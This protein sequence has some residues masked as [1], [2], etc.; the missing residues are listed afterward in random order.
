MSHR[1]KKRLEES[2][3]RLCAVSLTNLPAKKG[4]KLSGNKA[5]LIECHVQS[6]EAGV[7]GLGLSDRTATRVL[8]KWILQHNGAAARKA[9]EICQANKPVMLAQYTSFMTDIASADVTISAL[10]K[11]NLVV[12]SQSKLSET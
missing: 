9:M 4:L 5:P 2:F 1:E 8:A 3:T 12:Q 6:Y 11:I 10:K 7:A